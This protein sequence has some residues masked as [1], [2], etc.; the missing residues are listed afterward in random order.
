MLHQGPSLPV[1]LQ[2]SCLSDKHIIMSLVIFLV[3]SAS[4]TPSGPQAQPYE[5]SGSQ[6][7]LT[8]L[9]PV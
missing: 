4:D 1:N 8:I 6:V 3:P 9:F 7:Y 5:A 2:N